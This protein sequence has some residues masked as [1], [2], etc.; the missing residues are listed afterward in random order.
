MDTVWNYFFFFLSFLSFLP[1]IVISFGKC[2]VRFY[3]DSYSVLCKTSGA[4]CVCV[5]ACVRVCVCACVRAC[6]CA[7]VCVCVCVDV[8][9]CD[10]VSMCIVWCCARPQ[11]LDC[12]T[13][14]FQALNKIKC[15]N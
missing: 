10:T 13:T 15:V 12:V 14:M 4:V 7:C 6:V 11:A 3:R 1:S 8:C 2:D 5:C 9:V